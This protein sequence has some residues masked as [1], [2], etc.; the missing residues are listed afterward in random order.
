MVTPIYSS[1]AT[2]GYQHH[3]HRWDIYCNASLECRDRESFLSSVVFFQKIVIWK[4]KLGEHLKLSWSITIFLQGAM[5]MQ[6]TCF[7][8]EH[9]EL[10]DILQCCIQTFFGH[11]VFHKRDL[12]NLVTPEAPP[13]MVGA[14]GRK[15]SN[16]RWSRRQE[17]AISR[18]NSNKKMCKIKVSLTFLEGRKSLNP[19]SYTHLTLP[20]NREV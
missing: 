15:C 1:G 16:L 14:E 18:R 5:K 19:V 12:L 10:R 20:T 9:K 6:S 8:I 11:T 2:R 13:P 7:L 17:K 3:L 4:P